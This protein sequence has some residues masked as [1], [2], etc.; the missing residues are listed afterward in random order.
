MLMKRFLA[1]YGNRYWPRFKMSHYSSSR[2]IVHWPEHP[3][4]S[5]MALR[6]FEWPDQSSTHQG[7]LFGVMSRSSWVRPTDL[8]MADFFISDSIII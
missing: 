5:G 1:N 8:S 4:S 7:F 3:Q 2:M 6:C